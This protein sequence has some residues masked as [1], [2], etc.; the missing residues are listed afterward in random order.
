MRLYVA[1]VVVA[2]C[3]AARADTRAVQR[4]PHHQAAPAPTNTPPRAC[5]ARGSDWRA[6]L[7]GPAQS[8]VHALQAELPRIL[9]AGGKFAPEGHAPSAALAPFFDG[10]REWGRCAVVGG[11]GLLAA[12][13]HGAAIRAGGY[14]AVWS[15]N[16]SP[17]KG[18]ADLVG[19]RADI[20]FVTRS[21]HACGISTTTHEYHHG[22]GRLGK[23]RMS[24]A[25]QACNAKLSPPGEVGDAVVFVHPCNTVLC[26]A[27]AGYVASLRDAW[28]DR[29][30][31]ALGNDVDAALTRVARQYGIAHPTTGLLAALMARHLCR[32]VH[33]F[34]FYPYNTMPDGRRLDY[35]YFGSEGYDYLDQWRATSRVW[36]AGWHDL[37]RDYALIQQIADAVDAPEVTAPAWVWPQCPAAPPLTAAGFAR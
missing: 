8:V 11:S 23:A 2:F 30:V 13:K 1:V 20:R 25:R 36:R 19:D 14:D 24:A 27:D 6:A 22:L 35:N 16:Y 12:L 17:V 28:A 18:W 21:W 29:P 5:A 37:G 26:S 31:L 10:R 4:V 32:E 33:V 3:A 9:Y 15:A 7:P 34:G